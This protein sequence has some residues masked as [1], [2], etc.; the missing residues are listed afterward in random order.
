MKLQQKG[1]RVMKKIGRTLVV[2]AVAAVASTCSCAGFSSMLLR[3]PAFDLDRCTG[4]ARLIVRGRLDASGRVQAEEVFKGDLPANALAL[5]DGANLF[6][7]FQAALGGPTNPPAGSIEVVAFLEKQTTNDLWQ[8]VS[9]Y[10]GLAGLENTNVWLREI[11]RFP[12]MTDY[13]GR[14]APQ[15]DEHFNRTSF[16]AATREQVNLGRQR[17][18]LL[19]LPPSAARAQQLITFLRAHDEYYHRGRIVQTWRPLGPEENREILREMAGTTD[20][21]T[22]C[23]LVGLADELPMGDDAFEIL[24]PWMDAQYPGALRQVA[25]EA[26]ARINPAATSQRLLPMVHTTEPE[27][28]AVLRSLRSSRAEPQDGQIIGALFTLSGEVRDQALQGAHTL[29]NEEQSELQQA[30]RAYAHPRLAAFYYHWLTNVP[31][32]TINTPDPVAEDLRTLLG[33]G[34]SR[35]ELTDW[36]RRQGA[37]LETVYHLP[38]DEDLGRWL[39]AYQAGDAT[40]RHLLLR[41]WMYV[42]GTNQV[43]LVRAATAG[44]TADTAKAALAGLWYGERPMANADHLSYEAKQALFESFLKFKFVD[45][46]GNYA[47]PFKNRHDLAIIGTFDFPFDAFIS[48]RASIIVDGRATGGSLSGVGLEPKMKEW[49]FGSLS[50]AVPG[51]SASATIDIF[52]LEHYPDGKKLWQVHQDLGPIPLPENPGGS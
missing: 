48:Y 2:L 14:L 31:P 40:A 6:S 12:V 34:G 44:Q 47:Q 32:P 27:L 51:K 10:A 25:M 35:E 28:A 36:W 15:R 46:V 30:L 5:V 7:D 52:Q 41:W 22:R 1:F 49:R 45:Q 4:D 33:T 50:G 43:A 18:T 21:D 26:G 24:A 11:G 3:L 39:A 9:D 19:A 23:F 37:A 8:P 17:D 38:A 20:E 13:S 29:S 16:L 42:P